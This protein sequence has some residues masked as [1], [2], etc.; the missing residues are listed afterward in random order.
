M[1]SVARCSASRARS[2]RTRSSRPRLVDEINRTPPKTQSAL[3]EAMQE[4]SVTID[5]ETHRLPDRFMVVATQNPVEHEGTYPLP[6]AQLDRFLFKLSVGYPAEE[7]EVQAVLAH[8]GSSGTPDLDSLGLAP[9]VDPAS[10]DALRSAPAHVHVDPAIAAYAVRLARATRT[11]PSLSVGLSPRAATMLTA[12]ARAN[13]A[14][15]GRNYVIPD[16]LKALF[17]A[18]ARHRVITTP[19]AEMEDVQIDDVLAALAEEVPAPR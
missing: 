2:S 19:A 4:R 7:Q 5:G 12:A 8:C 17:V 14:C 16:D 18:G 9:V 11:H 13:A 10:L 6:E 3:L 1:S 15:E